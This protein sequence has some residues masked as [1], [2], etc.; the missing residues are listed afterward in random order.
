MQ[1][2]SQSVLEATFDVLEVSP[3]T[4]LDVSPQSVF[5]AHL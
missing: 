1:A 2:T 5:E 4:V 3:Q